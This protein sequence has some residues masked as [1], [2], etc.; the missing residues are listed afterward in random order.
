MR[1][2]F[3]SAVVALAQTD[4]PTNDA[5]NPYHVVEGWAKLPNGRKM[6]STSA[7]DVDKD[8]KSI[9]VAERCGANSCLDRETGQIKDIPVILKFDPD[10]NVV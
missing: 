2:L 3:L 9:W 5:P 6:G 1:F 10:G 7:V 8:G 4:A